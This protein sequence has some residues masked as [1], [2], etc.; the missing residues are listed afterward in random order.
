M[1][2]KILRYGMIIVAGILLLLQLFCPPVH[3]YLQY[4]IVVCIIISVFNGQRYIKQADVK[5]WMIQNI[6]MVAQ[7]V[8][9]I[10]HSNSK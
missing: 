2:D 3:M 4:T 8:V 9:L 10:V 7:V 1:I 6:A 5:G